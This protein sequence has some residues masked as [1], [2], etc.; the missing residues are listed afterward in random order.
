MALS[1]QSNFLANLRLRKMT[2]LPELHKFRNMT[3][4]CRPC[5]VRWPY[6]AKF[7]NI[8]F[9]ELTDCGKS[10]LMSQS[11]A[12]CSNSDV[13]AL[14]PDKAILLIFKPLKIVLCSSCNGVP[15]KFK[16][17]NGRASSLQA[18]IIKTFR[19]SYSNSDRYSYRPGNF[20][21]P[22]TMFMSF[23]L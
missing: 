1:D 22:P 8:D 9:P 4:S 18:R 6:A 10:I 7:E 17:K 23:L 2:Y 15:L 5:S 21:F 19:I 16:K 13:E 20:R 14:C 12:D 3:I 11:I